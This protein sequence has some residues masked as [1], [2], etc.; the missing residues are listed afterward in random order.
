MSLDAR[1]RII[2]S[3]VA[4]EAIAEMARVEK[5]TAALNKQAAES[6]K[7]QQTMMRASKL[8]GAALLGFAAAGGVALFSATRL[9][10]RVETL[11]VVTRQLGKTAGFTEAQI[12]SFEK[13]IESQ[14][15]TLRSTRESMALMMQSQID[16]AHGADLARIAQDA[17]VIANVNSSEAFRRLVFVITSGNARMARTL[18]FQVSFQRAYEKTAEE[19]GKT[20][21]ELTELERVQARTNEVMRAGTTIVGTYEAA[22]TTAG[23]KILSL[24]RHIEAARLAIGEAF[25][26]AL[27]TAVD[28]LTVFLKKFNALTEAQ[29]H[30]VAA[31]MATAV[32][33][34]AV[35]GAIL[36]AIPVVFAL[37]TAVAALG[38]A[39]VIATGGLV[40][41]AAALAALGIAAVAQKVKT[42]AAIIETKK[43][44][45]AAV[46]GTKSYEEYKESIEAYSKESGVAIKKTETAT[47]FMYGYEV[48]VEETTGSVE[49]MTEAQFEQ[50]R[51]LAR[52]DARLLNLIPTIRTAVEAEEQ[53]ERALKATG[54]AMDD[55]SFVMAGS[56][57]KEYDSFV[58]KNKKLEDQLSE[59]RSEIE[60]LESSKWP[61]KSEIARVEELREKEAELQEQISAVAREH[62][63]ATRQI[64]FDLAA[65]RLAL[66]DLPLDEQ[67]EALRT[68]ATGWGLMDDKTAEAMK[69]VDAA[70]AAFLEGGTL[71]AFL[72]AMQAQ[73]DIGVNVNLSGT[74]SIT[75][76]P[77]TT[78]Q[79]ES[80]SKAEKVIKAGALQHGGPLGPV[81][82]VGEAGPE[83]IINGVVVPADETRKL[84]ALGLT[85][86]R[87]LQGGGFAFDDDTLSQLGVSNPGALSFQQKSF[88][89]TS[90]VSAA[91]S[92]SSGGGGGTTAS[93]TEITATATKAAAET[94]AEEIIPAI[95][96]AVIAAQSGAQQAAEALER[97]QVETLRAQNRLIALTEE[98]VEVTQRQGDS[99]DI[100][101]SVR[102][103]MQSVGE[104]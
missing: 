85:P 69:G 70:L 11:G 16:L 103:A 80:G 39:T 83:L 88:I 7:R 102:D 94:V 63:M 42:E 43:L 46:A 28:G 82:L 49:L 37:T 19:V 54:Q 33:I 77:G 64:L 27:A 57:G 81:S 71:A 31:A 47:R 92:G 45:T 15:I 55:L 10:A 73:Y 35:S 86:H 76:V 32:A 74:S 48:A 58:D 14:G 36:L 2:I 60:E 61:T 75:F 87:K 12:G 4:T 40:L 65:Q 100:G 93:A 90:T 30:G 97:S 62:Q 24:P 44:T 1:A 18:G 51:S 21:A 72:S 41:V 56:L 5:A 38:T 59:V 23:K 99:G 95:T 68:L 25:V 8:A 13:A 96:A 50:A 84:L 53:Q 78:R 29:K 89:T 52:T 66:S 20:V 3:A 79:V 98:L 26:P 67:F 34:A 6:A 17:A 104:N 91:R 101:I 22:M 9:A